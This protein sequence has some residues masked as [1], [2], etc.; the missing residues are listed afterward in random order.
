MKNHIMIEG[1]LLQTNKKF[2]HLKQ[3]QKEKIA[4]W[5]YEE[6]KRAIADEGCKPGHESDEQIIRAVMDKIAEH[7][8]WI[9][10]GEVW[11]YYQSKQNRMRKRLDK[12]QNADSEGKI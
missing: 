3:A 5:L 12:E 1:Q 7:K 2:S 11:A 4:Q 8:I 10:E 9:P 6:Y